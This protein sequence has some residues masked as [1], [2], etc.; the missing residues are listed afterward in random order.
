[1]SNS[2]HVHPRIAT[3]KAS[4]HMAAVNIPHSWRLTNC[5]EFEQDT[6]AQLKQ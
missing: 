5:L 1:M 3:A 2:A 4:L 6:S